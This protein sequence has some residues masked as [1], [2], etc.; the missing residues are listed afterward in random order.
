MPDST[1]RLTIG[2]RSEEGAAGTYD[3]VNPANEEIVGRAPEA[4]VEQANAAVEAAAEAFDSWSRTTPE[5]RA[6]LLNKAADLIDAHRDEIVPVL[7]AETGA[8]MRV[9]KTMQF[10]QA[11]A[12]LRRYAKGAM[13]SRI[14]PLEPAVMPTTALAPGGLISAVG[15]RAPVGV[16]TCITSYNFPMTNMAGKIGPAL[17]MGNTVVVKP[18]PQDPLGVVRMVE[19]M[20]EAGFPPGVVNVVTGNDIA[21]SEAVVAHPLTDMVSFTGS[22]VVGQRIGAVCGSKMKRQLMELGGKGA[23]IVF[24]DADLKAAIGGISS[25]W[26][27][28]SGQICTSPTRVI[29]QRGVYDH[30]VG[31][32]TK[33]AGHMKVGDPLERDTVVGPVISGVHR[34]RI[35]GFIST[36]VSE[37]ATVA[38]GGGRGGMD[39]GFFIEPT[40][41]V[42]CTNEMTPVREEIF[43]PVVVVVPFDDEDEA[44]AIANDSDYGLYS[45]VFSA[46]TGRAWEVAKRLRSGNVGIN[47]LQRNHEAPFGGFKQSGVGR[48]GGDFGLHAYSEMQSIVWPG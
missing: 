6:E 38:V 25:V 23:C 3:I 41:L 14:I 33:A 46:D 28:H 1:Y 42:D 11:S 26:G 4:S 9:A 31:G 7:Q 27:F 48:D 43:G 22:T 21:P 37:G 34:D 5:E 47:T 40:L 16:V 13:Q 44:I 19:L 17:A 8:T 15:H 10:P 35:E 45:Y 12:R 18:A 20:N 39:H 29:V 30:L 2:G 24:D 32:L 36:G